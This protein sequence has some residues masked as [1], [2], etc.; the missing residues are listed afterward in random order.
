MLLDYGATTIY[1]SRRWVNANKLETTKFSDKNIRVKLGDNQIVEA[2]LEVLPL[3]IM[4]TGLSETYKCVAVVYAIPEEFDY[5]LGIPFFEDMQPQIDR[6]GRRI[7]G[8][9]TKTLRW[10]RSGETCGP[11]EE[12]GP[13]ITSGLRRSVEAKGLS[14]RRPDSCRGAALKTD[15]KS[16]VHPDCEAVQR[17]SPSVVREQQGYAAAGKGS[18]VK[19]GVEPS[20][21]GGT[22]REARD[23]SSTK[24]K[25]TIVEKMFTIGIDDDTGVGTKYITRKKLRKLLRIETKSPDEPGFMLVISNETTKQTT[26]R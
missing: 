9:K 14:A 17:D 10:D 13:V 21:R 24:G 4:V 20:E 23:S 8:T 1:E 16:A 19:D 26:L 18:V 2:E 11:I 12:G 25:E 5:I 6:R 22:A 3:E 7:E 15:V